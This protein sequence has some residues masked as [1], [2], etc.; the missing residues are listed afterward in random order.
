MV[1]AEIMDWN[2]E[3]NTSL[4]LGQGKVHSDKG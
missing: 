4:D 1:E 3:K 2:L